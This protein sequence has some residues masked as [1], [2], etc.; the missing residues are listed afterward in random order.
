MGTLLYSAAMSLDGFI[1]GPG[2]DMSWLAAYTGP[3]PA[4]D[5]LAAETGALLVGRR[6]FCGDD[7]Y[8]GT[9]GEGKAFGCGWDGP[10]VVLTRQPLPAAAGVTYCASLAEG[11][12]LA[13]AAAGEKTVNVL[14]ASVGLACV[15]AGLLDEVEVMVMPVLLGDGVRLF[16]RSGP[17]VGLEL[18]WQRGTTLRYRVV[19]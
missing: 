15:G 5:A 10:Q 3:N 12:A 8:R 7:P 16:S 19:P 14:G 4:A 1:A 9:E 17:P 2:G 11:V 6:T 18:S 13:Q